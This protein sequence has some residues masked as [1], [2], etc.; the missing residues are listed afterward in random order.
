MKK[1]YT[2]EELQRELTGRFERYCAELE[3]KGIQ[4]RENDVKIHIDAD[5][6][7][8]F[9]TLYLNQ[10]I[11]RDADTEILTIERNEEQDESGGTDD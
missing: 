5:S 2:K 6:A 9:G 10:R 1:S 4:I 7:D 3:E 11:T 8:A